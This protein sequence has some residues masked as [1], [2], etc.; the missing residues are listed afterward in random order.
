MA[1]IQETFLETDW[2]DEAAARQARDERAAQLQAQ[3]FICICENLY[4]IAGYRV[5]VLRATEPEAVEPT[6][7][8]ERSTPRRKQ[9]ERPARKG[10]RPSFN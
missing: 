7:T 8:G 2:E 3:G 1:A 9:M 5:F 4:N 10:I 6:A